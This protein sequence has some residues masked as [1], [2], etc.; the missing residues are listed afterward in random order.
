M[1]YESPHKRW[2]DPEDRQVRGKTET[3]GGPAHETLGSLDQ[4]GP[5]DQAH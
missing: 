5:R 3:Y 4:A 1:L 2:Q